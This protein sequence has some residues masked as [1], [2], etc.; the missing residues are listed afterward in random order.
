MKTDRLVSFQKIQIMSKNSISII[1]GSY[2][3]E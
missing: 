1:G 2:Y 3:T